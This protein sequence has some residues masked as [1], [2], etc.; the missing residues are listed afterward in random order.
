MPGE[1]AAQPG[2]RAE[3][4]RASLLGTRRATRAGARSALALEPELFLQVVDVDAARWT[5][6]QELPTGIG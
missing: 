1:T 6:H 2:A 3:R 5:A 4:P